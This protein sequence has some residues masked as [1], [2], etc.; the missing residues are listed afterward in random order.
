[1]SRIRL[2]FLPTFLTLLG[3]AF[4]VVVAARIRAYNGGAGVR[5]EDGEVSSTISGPQATSR[6]APSSEGGDG[7]TIATVASKSSPASGNA[8]LSPREQRYRELLNA[9][10]PP[11]P[12][13]QQAP[14]HI[15]NAP[16]Q[17]EK[18]S[19]F[20]KIGQ[21]IKKFFNGDKGTAPPP[22]PPVPQPKP[23]PDTGHEKPVDKDPNTDTTPP[24]VTA[25]QFDPP[26]VHDGDS[27]AVIVTA[28]DDMSGIRGISGTITSPTGKALQGF[29]CQ[30]EAPESN[31]YVGRLTIPKD[32][33]EGMWHINFLNVSDNASNSVTLAYNQAPVLQS[34]QLQVTSSRSDKTPPTVK[35]AWIDKRG[36]RAGEKNTLF[37]QA[38]DDKS[39]VNLVSGVFLSPKKQARIGV[40]CHGSGDGD[41][42]TCDFTVPACLD[43]GDWQ[44]EQIQLQDKAS[45]MTA[46]TA[47]ASDIVRAVTVN[48]VGDSCDPDAPV[49]QAVMLDT[50]QVPST[51]EGTLVN[52][53]VAV[54][55]DGC[56]VA[57]VSGQ[58]VG[59]TGGSGLFFAFTA[60]G[61]QDWIGKMPIPKLAGKGIWKI[62]WLQVMDKGNN[63]RVYF[64]SDPL[65]RNAFVN[66]R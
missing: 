50:N 19:A 17:P 52:V 38:Q 36:M 56:G 59:P 31:R 43:C 25:L 18:Q 16:K 9:H 1:M 14:V 34:A 12:A 3:V 15:V 4:A 53:R 27:V 2:P 55:D 61:A 65:L 35:A 21:E 48:I 23:N 49:L 24:S 57:S 10:P 62:N 32:A 41:L 54:N 44:L 39:G 13:G 26:S 22:P 47:A 6:Y 60:A 28:M 46:V 33:E 30:R 58:V 11:G 20:A 8:K 45:N 40:A 37:V 66:V 7:T 51:P 29:A 63:L 5:A 64:S 42:W